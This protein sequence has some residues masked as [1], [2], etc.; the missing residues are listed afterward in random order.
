M[1]GSR[2]AVGGLDGI[3]R[4]RR[5]VLFVDG[6]GD[7]LWTV[8]RGTKSKV[9]VCLAALGAVQPGSGKKRQSRGGL[10]MY[11]P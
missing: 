5:N 7:V 11:L 4:G 1:A 2:G 3:P 8:V 6:G 10:S 9:E